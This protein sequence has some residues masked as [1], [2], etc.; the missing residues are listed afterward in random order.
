MFKNARLTFVD[1][2][3]GK[4]CS[5]NIDLHMGSNSVVVIVHL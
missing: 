5:N 3:Y 2:I 4:T 1:T